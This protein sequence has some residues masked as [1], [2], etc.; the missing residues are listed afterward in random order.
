MKY[1]TPILIAIILAACSHSPEPVKF[2]AA[3]AGELQKGKSTKAD[4][5]ATLGNPVAVASDSSGAEKLTYLHTDSDLKGR[6]FIP[7]AGPWIG[8]VRVTTETVIVTLNR[9]IV[10]NVETATSNMETS[11]RS[12]HPV[13]Q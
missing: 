12:A 11:G 8:G 1:T 10:S 13:G 5:L 7:F 2:Q 4:V 6:S 9:G 3:R